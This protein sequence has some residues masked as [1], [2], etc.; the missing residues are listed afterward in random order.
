VIVVTISF[1]DVKR[2]A[3]DVAMMQ[4]CSLYVFE[5]GFFIG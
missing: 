3:G 5:G 2:L 4:L 1:S